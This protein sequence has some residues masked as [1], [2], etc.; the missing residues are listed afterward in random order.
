MAKNLE[1]KKTYYVLRHFKGGCFQP[2]VIFQTSIE[3]DAKNYAEIERRANPEAEFSVA[4]G[5]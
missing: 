3:E 2:S 1:I 4:V 5:I